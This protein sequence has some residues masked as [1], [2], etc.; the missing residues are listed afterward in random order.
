MAF[1]VLL[2][3]DRDE[4]VDPVH[5]AEHV[6]VVGPTPVVDV[7]LPERLLRTGTDARVVADDVHRA[8]GVERR[9]AQRLHR[10]EQPHVGDDAGRVEALA[11]QLVD[12]LL[13][14][15]AVVVGQHDL[16]AGLPEADTER[17]A[18]AATAAGDDGDLS[19]EV[20]HG[21]VLLGPTLKRTRWHPGRSCCQRGTRHVRRRVTG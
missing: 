1:G 11:A 8:V 21:A 4:R 17:L 5:D 2:E 15:A 3:H 9:V 10:L 13:E 19:F 16:H 20:L 6:D 7:L 12:G 14:Q 18:D